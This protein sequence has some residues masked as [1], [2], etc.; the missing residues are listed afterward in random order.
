MRGP[1]KFVQHP[2]RIIVIDWLAYGLTLKHHCAI[3]A[4]D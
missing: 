3:S 2:A 4:N 1:A